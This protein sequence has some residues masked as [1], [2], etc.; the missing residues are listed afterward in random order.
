MRPDVG[1]IGDGRL[2]V[3]IR[4]KFVQDAVEDALG[5]PTRKSSVDGLPG[6][7]PFGEITPRRARLGDEEHRIHES[8]VGKY[9]RSRPAAAFRRQQ[10]GNPVPFGVGQLVASH[11][12][13]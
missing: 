12:Q 11:H 8:A 3:G 13:T 6:A 2:M 10:R 9:H 7:E 5:V 1:G 4:G